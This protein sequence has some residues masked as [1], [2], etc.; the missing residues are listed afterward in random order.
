MTT[1]AEPVEQYLEYLQGTDRSPNTIKSY[2]RGLALWW[3]FLEQRS[4]V[5]DAVGVTELGTFIGQLRRGG[6]AE[7]VV[8]LRAAER[9][10]DATVASRMRAVLGFYRYQAARE[11]EVAGR[12]YETVYARP[13]SYLPFLEHVALKHGRRSSVGKYGSGQS[14]SLSF[15]LGR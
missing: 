13:G 10:A 5:W 6:V 9:A 11:V 14:P 15:C 12:L 8:P 2:A 1:G 7:E 3:S 4:Q